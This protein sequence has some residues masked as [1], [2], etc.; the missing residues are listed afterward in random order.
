MRKCIQFEF[1]HHQ[2][3]VLLYSA[4]N[5]PRFSFQVCWTVPQCPHTFDRLRLSCVTGYWNLSIVNT[6]ILPWNL[7]SSSTALA[8]IACS[9]RRLSVWSAPI[10]GSWVCGCLGLL[11]HWVKGGSLEVSGQ[12]WLWFLHCHFK[13][14]A[15]LGV[16]HGFCFLLIRVCN[17]GYVVT[18]GLSNF[19]HLL[20]HLES[21][22]LL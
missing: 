22:I 1:S 11:F 20:V 13:L 4:S 17:D 5:L 21:C 16:S 12:V 7:L 8:W 6:V 3:S 19:Q 18:S 15:L 14:S 10:G 9:N 2:H